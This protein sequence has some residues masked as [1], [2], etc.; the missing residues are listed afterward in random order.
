MS[1]DKKR[2]KQLEIDL[3]K[4]WTEH[5]EIKAK[6]QQEL[7]AARLKIADYEAALEEAAKWNRCD[8][9]NGEAGHIAHET[10]NKWKAK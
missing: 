5:S 4:A 1:E 9:V 10:L 3:E 7:D 8:D 6:L 2:I